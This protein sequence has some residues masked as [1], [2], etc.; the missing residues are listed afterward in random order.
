MSENKRE[1]FKMMIEFG[2]IQGVLLAFIVAIYTYLIGNLIFFMFQ[3]SNSPYAIILTSFAWAIFS[4]I[5]GFFSESQ[6]SERMWS[7]GGV[8]FVSYIISAGILNYLYNTIITL[9]SLPYNSLPTMELIIIIFVGIIIGVFMESATSVLAI[10][11][12][13]EAET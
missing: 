7:Y 2:I 8:S 11:K 6:D 1:D 13:K 10:F 12:I 4:I 3:L 5:I 9:L